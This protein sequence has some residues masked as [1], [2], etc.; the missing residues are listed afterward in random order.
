VVAGD[1]I[2]LVDV[3]AKS[4][5]EGLSDGQKTKSAGLSKPPKPKA[6][7][8]GRRIIKGLET[9]LAHGRGEIELAGYSVTVTKHKGKRGW[10]ENQ[11]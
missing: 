6:S 4:E 3:C 9:V 10:S 7:A 8:L 11:S 2:Y 5:K 1:A